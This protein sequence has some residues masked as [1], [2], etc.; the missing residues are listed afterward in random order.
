LV[1][2]VAVVGSVAGPLVADR[3]A[4]FPDAVHKLLAAAD[5]ERRCIRVPP[6]TPVPP[7]RRVVVDIGLLY[8]LWWESVG[9]ISCAFRV[10]SQRSY[11]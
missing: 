10:L 8:S 1:V 11:P 5:E 9:T 2:G 4:D 7:E 6:G 3:M